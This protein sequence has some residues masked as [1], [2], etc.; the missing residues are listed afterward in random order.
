VHTNSVE[1]SDHLVAQHHHFCDGFMIKILFLLN[2]Y[3]DRRERQICS[4]FSTS[5]GKRNRK[6]VSYITQ[7][8]RGSSTA[9]FLM[10]CSRCGDS[11]LLGKT[12]LINGFDWKRHKRINFIPQIL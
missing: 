6:V 4:D 10:P 8:T 11:Q 5:S 9:L 12:V 3:L 1:S 2:G 7:L